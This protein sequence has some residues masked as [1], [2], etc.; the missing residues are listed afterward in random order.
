VLAACELIDRTIRTAPE[1]GHVSHLRLE[2]RGDVVFDAHYRGPMV[3]DVFSVTK[4][5]LAMLVGVAVRDG[6]VRDLDL[7]IGPILDLPLGGQTIRHLLTMTRG[8]E[9]EGRY[10][11]DEVAAL[12]GGWLQ[13]I[14]A[15]PALEPPGTGFRYDNGGTHLLAAVLERL[16]EEPL[17]DYADRE[18]FQPLDIALW[19]WRR[20]PDGLPTGH[21]HLHLDAAA[22]AALGRL[23][24]SRGHHA[25][26]PLLDPDFTREMLSRHTGGGPP[27][28]RPYGYLIWLDDA[29][30]M[31]GGWAGQHVHVL[32][33][34]DAVVVTTGDP[35]FDFGPPP[36]H[37][38]PVGWR[39]AHDLVAEHLL[40][41]LEAEESSRS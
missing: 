37:R 35:Q 9:T 41:V 14:A 6:R 15:A 20:D 21:A 34:A 8:C 33:A 24:L 26:T 19:Q 11:I 31:A 29:G 4:S 25:G 27:E 17:A 7:P 30:P 1:F 12:D 40:P 18:L 32:P 5:V 2:R 38:L 3:A 36:S 28:G 39:P 16:L 23:W 22:L 13:R 10:D